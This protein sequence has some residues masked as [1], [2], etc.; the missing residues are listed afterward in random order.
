M[1]E[2]RKNILK[3]FKESVVFSFHQTLQKLI[4][5]KITKRQ[6]GEKRYFE[7]FFLKDFIIHERHR[8]RGR[9]ISRG[10]SRLPVG[11]PVQDSILGP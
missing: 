8:E 10:K 4:I 3:G 7:I 11:S 5:Y 2:W 6:L 1:N 9:D